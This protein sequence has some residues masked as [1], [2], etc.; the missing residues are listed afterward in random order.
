MQSAQVG[1]CC[2]RGGSSSVSVSVSPSRGDRISRLCKDEAV[3]VEGG[4]FRAM[5]VLLLKHMHLQND[6][7][8]DFAAVDGE[9]MVRRRTKR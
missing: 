9:M 7:A 4:G 3:V 5:M 2:G 6:V 1:L 8:V